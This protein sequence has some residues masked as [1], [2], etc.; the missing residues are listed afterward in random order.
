MYPS[1]TTALLVFLGTFLFA[2]PA[3]AAGSTT[4]VLSIPEYP[5]R[6]VF[7]EKDGRIVKAF[8]E[9]RATSG[10]FLRWKD[11]VIPPNI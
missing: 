10:V 3:Y 9:H 6:I 7:T 1:F 4:R 5:F 11:F 2:F 8:S